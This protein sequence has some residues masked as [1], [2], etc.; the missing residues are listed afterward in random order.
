MFRPA[1][2]PAIS[3][4]PSHVIPQYITAP[5]ALVFLRPNS[6]NNKAPCRSFTST[7]EPNNDRLTWDEFLRLRKQRR[8]TGVLASIP[9]AA[10]GIYTGLSTF[11]LGEIDPA[12]TILGFDP[13]LMNAAFVFG[14]GIF[15]W[16]VGPTIGRGAWH[17]LHRHK[18]HLISLVTPPFIIFEDRETRAD[19]SVEG[20]TVLQTYREE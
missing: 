5:T 20:G 11:G 19:G 4:R 1:M 12:Q 8:I 14:C 3:L 16:L 9:T 6:L 7:S 10:V 17:L 18:T 15:G 2:R 13:F